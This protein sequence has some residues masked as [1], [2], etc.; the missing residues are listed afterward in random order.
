MP[1]STNVPKPDGEA[2]VSSTTAGAAAAVAAAAAT[3]TV[4]PLPIHTILPAT[5][6][7][8]QVTCLFSE[9][10][11]K[12]IDVGGENKY[13]FNGAMTY[14]PNTKWGLNAATYTLK[15]IPYAH[16]MSITA[17]NSENLEVTG[18]DGVELATD[19][20]YYWGDVKVTVSGDFVTASVNCL[21]H[22]YMGGKDLLV[23][24][25]TCPAVP[26]T[27]GGFG[28]GQ[29]NEDS[30]SVFN[31]A[32][33]PNVVPILRWARFQ[34]SDD[35]V[36]P[37]PETVDYKDLDTWNVFNNLVRQV[38]VS[39]NEDLRNSRKF[40]MFVENSDLQ[41][42][43]RDMETG[44]KTD[45]KDQIFSDTKI[46]WWNKTVLTNKGLDTQ[47]RFS[48][49]IS[50]VIGS[51]GAGDI[52]FDS[53]IHTSQSVE[54]VLKK[55]REEVVFTE[56]RDNSDKLQNILNGELVTY[57]ITHTSSRR[58]W[59]A[60]KT[61]GR[62]NEPDLRYEEWGKEKTLTRMLK[63]TG[64]PKPDQTPT[65]TPD[66]TPTPTPDQTPTPTPTPDQTPTPTPDQTP[67]PDTKPEDKIFLGGNVRGYQPQLL[68]G[69]ANSSSGSGMVGSNERGMSR[70]MLRK[71]FGRTNWLDDVTG[72]KNV[73][74][75][76]PFR[77]AMNAGDINGTKNASP[78][79]ELKPPNQVNGV[80]ALMGRLY[81]I[82]D[83]VKH[84]GA[85]YSGN[86]NY[87][88]DSSD[89][90]RYKKLGAKLKTYNTISFGGPPKSSNP[91]LMAMRK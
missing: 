66:Q 3:V 36:Q 40:L 43:D 44:K 35:P 16:R 26:T 19:G 75:S 74:K 5:S 78:M 91:F 67:T 30:L 41:V 85:A 59:K 87:V 83:G 81:G 61:P 9:T 24:S 56:Y 64:G 48:T 76:T 73:N 28:K 31:D 34:D 62:E 86:P 60:Q 63:V 6:S 13:V 33:A 89:Y 57:R 84:G 79:K 8:T 54:E 29:D 90:I 82:G 45:K 72:K 14:N 42:L 51:T 77:V 88:Y 71:S 70:T 47:L 23:F 7:L 22:G 27:S 10:S 15:N 32:V 52:I 49:K 18:N 68:G 1:D 58:G 17:T 50:R 53:S 20:K 25:Q 11:V 21:N 39:V 80:N 65:P 37:A 55:D 46:A 12:V 2:T 69:G 38:I 4:P